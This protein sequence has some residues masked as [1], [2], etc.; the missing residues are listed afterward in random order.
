MSR[1]WAR[2]NKPHAFLCLDGCK[3]FAFQNNILSHGHHDVCRRQLH[4][5]IA[6]A[7]ALWQQH[8]DF[9]VRLC[10]E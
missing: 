1:A 9:H 10:S 4:A 7:G 6:S 2:T 3:E 8:E 5:S